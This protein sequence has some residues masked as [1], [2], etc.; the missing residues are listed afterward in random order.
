LANFLVQQLPDAERF[1][2]A[3]GLGEATALD[4]RRGT[5]ENLGELTKATGSHEIGN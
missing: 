2:D 4:V 1:G 3:P 5:V